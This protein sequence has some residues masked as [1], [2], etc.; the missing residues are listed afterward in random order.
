MWSPG[1]GAQ[2]L[3][4]VTPSASRPLSWTWSQRG[5]NPFQGPQCSP[6]GQRATRAPV[7]PASASAAA[8]RVAGHSLFL[9]M[10]CTPRPAPGRKRNPPPLLGLRVCAQNSDKTQAFTLLLF[11]LKIKSSILGSQKVLIQGLVHEWPA[12]VDRVMRWPESLERSG[13]RWYQS[14]ECR[15]PSQAHGAPSGHLRYVVVI[16]PFSS[17]LFVI[18]RTVARQAFPTSTVLTEFSQ[19]HVHWVS[20]M[21]QKPFQEEVRAGTS[22]QAAGG[23]SAHRQRREGGTGEALGER[24]SSL[25]RGT[26]YIHFRSVPGHSGVAISPPTTMQG[27]GHCPSS[28]RKSRPWP[29][30][31][32]FH[33]E[34]LTTNR[35]MSKENEAG[36]WGWGVTAL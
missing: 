8:E 3:P 5:V 10:D 32:S 14:H 27:T 28:H 20:E 31:H 33:P 25:A 23:R 26:F 17:C 7:S 16:Q 21:R 11:E 35:S 19:I 13:L 15:A 6:C 30:E 2:Q 9:S 29:L 34:R 24:L 1:P 22:G 36:R 4:H 18:P 12:A